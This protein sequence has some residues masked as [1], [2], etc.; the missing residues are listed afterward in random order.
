[1][2]CC[3]VRCGAVLWGVVGCSEVLWGVVGDAVRC[4]G[5]RCGGVWCGAVRCCGVRCVEQLVSI[6]GGV[7]FW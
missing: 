7:V 6:L 5:V 3:A 1:M 4:C 2:D